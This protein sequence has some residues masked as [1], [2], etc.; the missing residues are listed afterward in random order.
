MTFPTLWRRLTDPT[1]SWLSE[2]NG[3]PLPPAIQAELERALAATDLDGW[4]VR[5]S[6]GLA[7]TDDAID[8]IEEAA[9]GEHDEDD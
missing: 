2:H 9:N 7:F 1:R 5:T 3:E 4:V 6:R 8:W